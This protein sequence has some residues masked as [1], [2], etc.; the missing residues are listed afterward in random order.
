LIHSLGYPWIKQISGVLNLVIV[1][2]EFLL[3]GGFF[4]GT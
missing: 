4:A 3:T 2:K 1:I